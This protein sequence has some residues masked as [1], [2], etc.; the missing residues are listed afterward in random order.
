MLDWINKDMAAAII[1]FL[2]F[3]AALFVWLAE[4]IGQW[5]GK[6]RDKG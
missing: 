2:C 1:V 5:D 6:P 3:C 4:H